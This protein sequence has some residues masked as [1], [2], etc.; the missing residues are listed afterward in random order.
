MSMCLGATRPNHSQSVPFQ[1]MKSAR[2]RISKRLARL[3]L[4]LAFFIADVAV[5]LAGS[6]AHAESKRKNV[7]FIISDDLNNQVGCYGAPVKTPT[8]DE[9]AQRG[10]RFDRAYCQ[11]SL[12]N[13][14]RVSFL[15]GLRP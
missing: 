14:S 13:P 5:V 12:C 4:A 15:S 7:L 10:M 11:N 3:L 9:L 1:H 8:I 6:A 2:D